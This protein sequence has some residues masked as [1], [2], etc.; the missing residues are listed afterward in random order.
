MWDN[1]KEHEGNAECLRKLTVEKDNI[2][3]H[4][5]NITTEMIKEKV[6]EIPNCKSPG[7]DRVQV[8][9]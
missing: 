4:Y 5:I 7:T 8:T 3:Q 6:K 1:D 9:G 2:K